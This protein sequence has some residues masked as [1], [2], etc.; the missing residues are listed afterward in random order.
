MDIST[1]ELTTENFTTGLQKFFKDAGL[2]RVITPTGMETVTGD[3]RL[4]WDN[5]LK[6][7]DS[8]MEVRH[9][10]DNKFI[11]LLF[12]VNTSTFLE[13]GKIYE[14]EYKSELTN[15]F[16]ATCDFEGNF[17][18]HR[19]A[20]NYL[21]DNKVICSDLFGNTTYKKVTTEIV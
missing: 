20:H 13:H 18:I 5:D 12:G 2:K 7:N 9:L 16:L 15:L 11:C 1:V 21:H 6:L 10:N 4:V 17:T 14:L 8:I 3:Y 19:T